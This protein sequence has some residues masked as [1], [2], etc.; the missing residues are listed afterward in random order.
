MTLT[1]KVYV[2]F[3]KNCATKAVM[4]LRLVVNEMVTVSPGPPA[5]P[6]PPPRLDTL[7]GRDIQACGGI[8]G[9]LNDRSHS[10][11]VLALMLGIGQMVPGDGISSSLPE[12]V[13]QG[14]LDVE[15]PREIHEAEQQ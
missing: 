8:L 11:E 7:N 14:N 3:L 2:P 1:V 5:L 15:Q 6:A 9:N 13:L 10:G 12:R 4:S